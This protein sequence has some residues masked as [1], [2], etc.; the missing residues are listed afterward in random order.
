MKMI[1]ILLALGSG[2]SYTKQT[3]EVLSHTP[4]AWIRVTHEKGGYPEKAETRWAIYHCRSSEGGKAGCVLAAFI[5]NKGERIE[6]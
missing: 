3:V 5:N 4:D 2:C 6:P 1:A